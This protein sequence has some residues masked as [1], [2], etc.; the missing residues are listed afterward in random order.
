MYRSDLN[1]FNIIQSTNKQWLVDPTR[2]D[3]FTAV[4]I[5]CCV[6][7]EAVIWVC[8]NAVRWSPSMIG[9]FC[10]SCANHDLWWCGRFLFKPSLIL[11]SSR[12]Q[13]VAFYVE[14]PCCSGTIRDAEAVSNVGESSYNTE[15]S[16]QFRWVDPLEH[17]CF[18][19]R[20][21]DQCSWQGES[22]WQFTI[23]IMLLFGRAAVCRCVGGYM[24]NRQ[25][26]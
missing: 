6:G 7:I 20:S 1:I 17:L 2:S 18:P 26:S 10:Q 5:L 22:D 9:S 4:G 16:S 21:R 14:M 23:E 12:W 15:S 19:P 24:I 13:K 25:R 3:H 11:V 8:L